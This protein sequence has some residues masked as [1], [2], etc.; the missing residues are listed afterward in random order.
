MKRPL[1]SSFL[2][3]LLAASFAA[4][5]SFNDLYRS[6]AGADGVPVP[7]AVPAAEAVAAVPS[8]EPAAAGER[9]WLVLVF[10]SGVNDLG[11]LNFA[12]DDV[13]EMERVGSTDK[14]AVVVEYNILSTDGSAANTLQFQR[15][16]KTLHIQRD[17]DPAIT[18][19]VIHESNDL[20]MGSW[21]HLA[22][23]ARRNILRFPAKKVMLV[24]WNHGSGTLGIAND[25]VAGS[26]IS[27]RDLGRALGQ[28]KAARGGKLDILA[29]DAC[30]M[31][32]AGVAYELKDHADVI[33]GSEEIIAGPGYPYHTMLAAMNASPA[34]DAAGM[35]RAVVAAYNGTYSS[36]RATLSALR[37]DRLGGF[38]QRLDAWT[39]A[40]LAD[41]AALRAAASDGV[42]NGTF[43]FRM[44][45]SK[46]LVDY[47][48]VVSDSLPAGSPAVAAGE[49][50][51]R[52]VK[53]DLIV[54]AAAGAADHRIEGAG[55][56]YA[57]RTHGL[58]VYVPFRIYDSAT[59]ESLAFAAD[60][61]WDDFL[62]ALMAERL[63]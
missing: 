17:A 60:S 63:K 49:A 22:K 36:S 20:D 51:K 48:D 42:I 58:A 34:Q 59:Y 23:F 41:P 25:D 44:P 8:E 10:I 35:G 5:G 53:E 16:A 61:R 37:T 26:K 12:N 33:V 57:A 52:Y 3:T 55:W 7:V 27:V 38:V 40:V 30:L 19:P 2:I 11:I 62:R 31:Q 13:N 56:S 18:S 6:A 28:I 1:T 29:T 14:V 54:A 39:A 15:G 46:D 32:M 43:Y 4:A 47:I 45:D 21:R 24:V 9:E 50:L